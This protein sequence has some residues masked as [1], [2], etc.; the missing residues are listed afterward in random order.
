MQAASASSLADLPPVPETLVDAASGRTFSRG[1]KLGK[2][3]FAECFELVDL[4][5]QRHFAGKVVRRASVVKQNAREKLI[6]EIKIHRSISHPH[7]VGFE[8]CFEDR[9]NIYM[10]LELCPNKSLAELVKK[11]RRISEPEAR[12]FLAQLINGVRFLH[13]QNVIH[14]DLKLGNLFLSEDMQ[15]K[16]GDFGL[17]THVSGDDDRRRTLCGTPNY[18]APEILNNKDGHSF[19]VDTWAL[20]IILYTLIIGKPPFETDSLKTTY[21]RIRDHNYSFPPSVPITPEARRLIDRLLSY[22]PAHRP[23]LEDILKDPFMVSGFTPQSLPVSATIAA[24][25]LKALALAST[26]PLSSLHAFDEAENPVPAKSCNSPAPAVGPASVNS[27]AFS[28]APTA[29][30]SQVGKANSPHA[31]HGGAAVVRQRRPLSSVNGAPASNSPSAPTVR[32]P[33]RSQAPGQQ[34]H[35]QDTRVTSPARVASTA[36]VRAISQRPAP[37]D[38]AAN[39]VRSQQPVRQYVPT[40][41]G[42]P[43]RPTPA[44]ASLPASSSSSQVAVVSAAPLSSSNKQPLNCSPV[45]KL[46]QVKL[47]DGVQAAAAEEFVPMPDEAQLRRMSLD[48]MYER[49]RARISSATG[50]GGPQSSAA[51]PPT[52]VIPTSQLPALVW[53]TRWVD[54]SNKYGLGY[55][56]SNGTVGVLLNDLGRLLLVPETQRV[57]FLERIAQ[58]GAVV[59]HDMT[60]T[61]YPA[62]M[63]RKITLLR[64]FNNY[65]SENL[66][67]GG[68][69]VLNH[70]ANL[71]RAGAVAE[72]DGSVLPHIKAW[73]RTKDAIVFR[74]SCSSVQ[75]NFVDHS[76][77]VISVMQDAVMYINKAGDS[78]V[79]FLSR[80]TRENAPVCLRRGH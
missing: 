51:L 49:L 9:D 7:V 69:S 43:A 36:N 59:T 39:P 56:L 66:V 29:S 30:A 41:D 68:E 32:S 3:G 23:T 50:D 4:A 72:S 2:G 20:G 14:R 38:V 71:G 19:E 25:D 73:L 12:Y 28:K 24:P 48:L 35:A 42:A 6:S 11:R 76:K 78:Q 61:Q 17:A 74:L 8:H 67:S 40:A 55:Q 10:V 64:Y 26:Q 33:Q 21:Q 45:Q 63:A 44:V 58:S 15:I 5:S 80:V 34:Q 18:M 53:V 37:A 54:Y 46:S 70:L 31:E 1:A 47:P 60:M 75:L 22:S 27:A 62:T 79:L 57:V 65:M 16:I 52:A 13:S 77:L